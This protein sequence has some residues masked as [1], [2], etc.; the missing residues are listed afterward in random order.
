MYLAVI[1]LALTD[2][3]Y[4]MPLSAEE[5]ESYKEKPAT[6]NSKQSETTSLL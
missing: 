6:E 2:L 4:Y 3:A 5:S 1:L